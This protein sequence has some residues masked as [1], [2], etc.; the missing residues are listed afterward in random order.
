[1]TTYLL[2]NASNLLYT[3]ANVVPAQL[4]VPGSGNVI[5]YQNSNNS[6]TLNLDN[7][8]VA[9]GYGLQTQEE[10]TKASEIVAKYDYDIKNLTEQTNKVIKKL[11]AWSSSVGTDLNL[12]N[13][14]IVTNAENSYIHV[15]PLTDKLFFIDIDIA[16]EISDKNDGL[17]TSYLTYN[18]INN[19]CVQ[20]E[21]GVM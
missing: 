19:N 8:F 2:S 21:W 11:N 12:D 14:N 10:S 15:S 4:A 3:N 16:P 17:I 1:M 20:R 18:F 6:Y 7:K 9:T 5:I 13:I